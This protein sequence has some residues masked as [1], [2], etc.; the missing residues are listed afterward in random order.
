VITLEPGVVLS[1]RIEA[2]D[3]TIYEDCD[4]DVRR[5]STG[6]SV[7]TPGDNTDVLGNY[8]IVIPTGTFE[9]L[10]SPPGPGYDLPLGAELHSGVV[11][12]G[13]T[14]LDGVLPHCPGGS[15]YGTGLA[16][17]GGVVP[18]LTDSGGAP[19]AGNDAYAWELQDGRGGAIAVLAG[20]LG[21]WSV[22]FR[23][24][25]LLIDGTPGAYSVFYVPLG[26]TSGAAGA[27]TATF[28][29]PAPII[30][31]VGVTV[32]GQFVVLDPEAVQNFAFSEGLAVTFCW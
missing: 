25:T 9:I 24:G 8:A 13:S 27:G 3:G 2:Y 14:V 7:V 31:L 10:F 22:P 4:V 28:P 29:F 11:V 15:N 20:S 32:Y 21:S 16:G 26:G 5:T 17:T 30:D 1:G 19:R 6:D 18:H 23:G 12:T